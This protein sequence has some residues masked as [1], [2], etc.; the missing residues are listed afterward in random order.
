MII[1]ESER[2]H[3]Q[4]IFRTKYHF[5]PLVLFRRNL[6]ILSTR[7]EDETLESQRVWEAKGLECMRYEEKSE[8][9]ADEGF[10]FE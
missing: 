6:S 1:I 4:M 10:R 5:W 2:A 7:L 3:Y 8:G 9:R